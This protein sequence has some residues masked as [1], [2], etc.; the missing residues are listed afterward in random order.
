MKA[1]TCYFGE[2]NTRFRVSLNMTSLQKK[3]KGVAY[4]PSGFR[5]RISSLMLWVASPKVS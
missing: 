1:H 5:R 4:V 2:S 3:K